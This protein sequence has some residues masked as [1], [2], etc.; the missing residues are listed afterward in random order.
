MMEQKKAGPNIWAL[1]KGRSDMVIH[2][3]VLCTLAYIP[4]ITQIGKF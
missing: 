4:L 3:P 1:K 2:V